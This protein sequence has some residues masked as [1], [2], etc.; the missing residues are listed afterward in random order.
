[1]SAEKCSSTEELGD[2]FRKISSTPEGIDAV[3]QIIP[4]L[5]D[6]VSL[7][8]ER[9]NV[10]V[11]NN[12]YRD[13]LE[14]R[15][16]EAR[17]NLIA[18]FEYFAE[19]GD[20]G[21]PPIQESIR[22]QTK[23]AQL[24]CSQDFILERQNGSI[25]SIHGFPFS[26]ASS[27]K[28]ENYY[29]VVVREQTSEYI[30]SIPE[31]KS[32]SFVNHQDPISGEQYARLV[33]AWSDGTFVWIVDV[34]RVYLSPQLSRVFGFPTHDFDAN[35][36][37]NHVNIE[38]RF[39]LLEARRALFKGFS[40]LCYIEY[41][42][43]NSHNNWV[44][45]FERS[46]A[47]RNSENRVVR[48]LGA[49]RDT[50]VVH[51][52]ERLRASEE[53]LSRILEQSPIAIVVINTTNGRCL[54]SNARACD[55]FG[56][57]RD[58][59]IGFDIGA[60]H[61]ESG[62]CDT[63]R[64]YIS[65]REKILDVEVEM[66]HP[67]GRRFWALTSWVHTQYHGQPA[68][69]SWIQ[70]ISERKRAEQE[71]E[72]KSFLLQSILDNIN[73]GLVAFDSNLKL[74]VWNKRASELLGVPESLYQVGRQFSDFIRYSAERGEY[75]QN[76]TESVIQKRVEL[77]RVS[78]PHRFY[79]ALTSGKVVDVQGGAMP[80]GG[81]VTTYTDIT[82]LKKVEAALREAKE[83][84]EN[85]YKRL[86]S[87]QES[88]VQ[89]EKLASL[90]RLVAGVAHEINTPVGV[91]VTGASILATEASKLSQ[92]ISSGQAK[93]S[94]VTAFV[95]LA[96]E[97]THLILI[98]GERAARLI[99][100]FKQVAVD[101]TSEDHRVFQFKE[102]IEEVLQS[103]RPHLKKSGHIVEIQCSDD[104][105]LD[106]YPGPLSQ[107]LTNFIM[108]SLVHGYPVKKIGRLLIQAKEVDNDLVELRY[109]DDG[110]G[111]PEEHKSKI[112]DPFFTTK[113]GAGGSGLGLNIVFNI[114]NATLKGTI[115][116][117]EP[118]NGGAGFVIL[119]PRVTP[120]S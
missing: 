108:N 13:V 81:F 89:A 63:I 71:L 2:V 117:L 57:D 102:Y 62:A 24:F 101:Q 64:Q 119:F 36:W 4:F 5:S 42:I 51:E 30:S 25:V 49:L 37:L 79:R 103:L 29:A 32:L 97:T 73:Q 115:S 58:A 53:Q 8:D 59:L 66:S 54:F 87:T 44:W 61:C 41:R 70:D 28:K 21:V 46:I 110:V 47:V 18:L 60:L 55:L 68:C 7:Y 33:H 22:H 100:S 45:I 38:D 96:Q 39:R 6:G 86:M 83:N 15:E 52:H 90:G 48:V 75:G 95:G 17:K 111:I 34:N 43:R 23:L 91:T 109:S 84:A 118:L 82:E 113:R 14:L 93:K 12:F 50:T 10:V 27:E 88:L 16:S 106:S 99:Q 67:Q 74:Q 3:K 80:G 9:L 31:D 114:V 107:V 69:I 92:K 35:I 56:V 112:F 65:N 104:L 77:A 116:V 26:I 85:A 72:N 98:N 20:F 78:Q 120:R 40:D 1:M 105:I 76:I 94:D 11:C 19:R